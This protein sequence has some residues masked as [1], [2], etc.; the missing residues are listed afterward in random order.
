MPAVARWGGVVTA[1]PRSGCAS[2]YPAG[3]S[4]LSDVVQAM[5]DGGELSLRDYLAV[6]RRRRWIVVAVTFAIVA[7][8]L[9]ASFSQEKVY[10]AS[11]DVL[12]E[13]RASEE[14]FRPD[15][16]EVADVVG[17]ETEIEVMRSRSVREA[18]A[19]ELGFSPHVRIS[20]RGDTRVVV[21]S[22][23]DVDPARAARVA[24][25]YAQV[26]IETR[27]SRLIDD[28]VAAGEQVQAKISDIEQQLV[29]LDEPIEAL[30]VAI[31]EADSTT[32]REELQSQQEALIQDAA[33]QR[34]ALQA[35]RAAYSAQLS[36]LELA[37]NLTQTGGAQLVSDAQTPSAPFKPTPERSALLALVVGLLLGTGLAFLRDYLDDSIRTKE[38][39]ERATGLTTV[40]VI[41]AIAGWRD[42]ADARLV[43]IEAPNSPA[44]E[45]YRTL[46]TS[47]QFLGIDQPLRVVQ[48]TSANAGEG[49]TTTLAN[50]AIAL[51]RAG[52][53]VTV[54]CCDLRRPRLHEF[55]GL[56]N[57]VGFTSVLM[58]ASNLPRALQEVPGEN[59]RIH[60]LASGPIPPNPSELLSAARTKDLFEALEGSADIVLVD[61]PPVLPVTDALVLAGLVDA[62]L[63]I[64]SAELTTRKSAHRAYELLHQLGAPVVGS[65]LN[66]A[67]AD[68]GGYGYGYG[69]GGTYGYS[70]YGP[71]A[72]DKRR[73]RWRR[74]TRRSRAAASS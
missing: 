1:T 4:I 46:R 65:V 27:R 59:G 9:L 10:R 32:E 18:V 45:A 47:I 2:P 74:G 57:E 14:I 17:V 6:L 23:D 50:L 49:K 22:A 68:G 52:Q 71:R 34:S 44:T 73:R 5:T 38:D 8:S 30:E 69:Y 24:S 67:R 41:P 25:T 55:F 31:A 51:A 40:G 39:L 58:G 28:L 43:S 7:G 60:L 13:S 36:E 37:G 29:D 42:T 15:D 11:A 54:V 35:Q 26:Y 3:L 16:V 63:L 21:I 72:N 64:A 20:A 61:G 70:T 33:A 56:D 53:R 12:L 62:T 66:G 19:E 48:L